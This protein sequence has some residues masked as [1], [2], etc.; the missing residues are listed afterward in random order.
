M[1]LRS[2]HLS[3]AVLFALLVAA[4]PVAQPVFAASF[5]VNSLA[6]SDDGNCTT[7]TGGCTLREAINAANANA[8]ADTI[9]FSLSGTIAPNS[10]LPDLSGGGD[11]IDAGTAHN[12]VLS[13]R[14]WRQQVRRPMACVS[15][16]R[17]IRFVAW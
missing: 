5:V 17:T 2:R 4:L 3:L 7:S 1:P 16:R 13:A 9:T 12:I 8:G 6:D 11:T 15:H 14:I 10:Q